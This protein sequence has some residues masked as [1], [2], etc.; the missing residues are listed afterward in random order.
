M[1]FRWNFEDPTITLWF[2]VK[3]KILEHPPLSWSPDPPKKK[4]DLDNKK[5]WHTWV[6]YFSNF[7]IYFYFF[8]WGGGLYM[9]LYYLTISIQYVFKLSRNH[10]RYKNFSKIK[11]FR[12]YIIKYIKYKW[13]NNSNGDRLT[14][15]IPLIPWPGS[16]WSRHCH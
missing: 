6:R 8:F 2:L 9:Y 4:Y 3:N 5:S 7:I 1:F 16:Y 11:P 15:L 13:S 12:G 14:L 10:K